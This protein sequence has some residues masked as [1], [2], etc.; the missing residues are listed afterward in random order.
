[1]SDATTIAR[2]YAKAVF[3]HALDA[4]QLP[5][6]SLMLRELSYVVLN[7]EVAD[8]I[9]NPSTTQAMQAQLVLSVF[10]KAKKEAETLAIENFIALLA[11]NKRLLLLP[12]I[13]LQFEAL[14]AEQEKTLVATVSSFSAFTKVQEQQLIE[15]LSRRLQRQVTLEIKIDS[16]LIGGAVIRA[17]DFV[18]DGSVRGKL[19][20]LST[21]LVA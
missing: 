7:T 13:A 19:S 10:A 4:A 15:S 8:F 6:W 12:E 5:F 16:S 17:G 20:K 14:R 18:I 11:E 1:M 3:Q 2:P 21:E 9:S